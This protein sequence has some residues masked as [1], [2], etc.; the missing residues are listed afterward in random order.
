[1]QVGSEHRRVRA[2]VATPAERARLWPLAVE[3]YS[4]YADY[5]RKAPREIP[6]VILEP[7][8]VVA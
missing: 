6:M 8:S 3:S 7:S 5:Q 4:G 2:R 1:V